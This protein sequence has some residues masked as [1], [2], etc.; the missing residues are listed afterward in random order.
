MRCAPARPIASA[1]GVRCGEY[2]TSTQWAS[3]FMPVSGAHARRGRERE[4]GVVDRADRRDRRSAGTGLLARRRVGHAEEGR[5]LGARVRRRDRDVRQRGPVGPRRAR[6]AGLLLGEEAHRLAEVGARAAAER[7][8]GVDGVAAR[9]RDSLLNARGR[10][11]RRDVGERRRERR[12]ERL[13]HP[14]AVVAVVAASGGDEQHPPRAERL[15]Q[16]GEAAH[17]ACAEQQLLRVAGV[18]PRRGRHQSTSVW[19]LGPGPSTS[20]RT[21]PSLASVVT[22][23][24]SDGR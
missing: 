20:V 12:A 14:R 8:D 1:S 17:R 3:A 21:L 19:S 18:C 5:E 15:E 4:L 6:R 23:Q 13:A 10:D 22:E 7:H 24:L 9:L 2:A 11:V 16:L